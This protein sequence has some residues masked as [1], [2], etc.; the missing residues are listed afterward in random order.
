MRKPTVPNKYNLST[1][2][3][4]KLKT[5]DKSKIK[6]PLFWRNDG[7]SAWC[8]N[9]RTNQKVFRESMLND[10]IQDSFWLGIYD[11]DAP[12]KAGEIEIYFTAYGDMC[13]YNFQNFYDPSEIECE[14]DLRI[15]EMFLETI[16][17]LIDEGIVVL[18]DNT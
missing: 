13:I 6:E 18:D 17:L 2:D 4:K 15:Q 5:K 7:A 11:V 14:Q 12:K 16:N 10:G 3:L 9:K 8:I 1:E